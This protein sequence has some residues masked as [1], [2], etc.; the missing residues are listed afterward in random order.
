MNSFPSPILMIFDPM[1]SSVK[2]WTNSFAAQI[3]IGRGVEGE[4]PAFWTRP[5]TD[6][7]TVHFG[8]G[9]L[10]W[11]EMNEKM[12]LLKLNLGYF[13]LFLSTIHH[14]IIPNHTFNSEDPIPTRLLS[15]DSFD[16]ISQIFR[17]AEPIWAAT[18]VRLGTS[19][20]RSR[21]QTQMSTCQ[22]GC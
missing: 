17:P 14:P 2:L 1:I 22:R 16:P 4:T 18:H 15:C 19:N 13:S 10:G 21:G 6:R 12:T 8:W 9:L 11:T 20:K 3:T 7:S 5:Q